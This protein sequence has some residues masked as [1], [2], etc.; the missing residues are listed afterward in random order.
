MERVDPPPLSST[1]EL[2]HWRS[3]EVEPGH[4]PVAP[5]QRVSGVESQAPKSKRFGS[6]FALMAT[7]FFLYMWL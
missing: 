1:A 2:K 4:V 3:L 7:T 6:A 5:S